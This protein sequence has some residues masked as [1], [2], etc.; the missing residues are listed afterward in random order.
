MTRKTWSPWGGLWRTSRTCGEDISTV[1]EFGDYGEDLEQWR[2][3]GAFLSSGSHIC[4]FML[5]VIDEQLS[6]CRIQPGGSIFL[7][8][9]LTKEQEVRLNI[10][11][12]HGCLIS[13]QP[14]NELCC[15]GLMSA[16]LEISIFPETQT[17]FSD[18][19]CIFHCHINIASVQYLYS[20]SNLCRKHLLSEW[21]HT[22]YQPDSLLRPPGEALG[23]CFIH[24]VDL[25]LLLPLCSP[26]PPVQWRVSGSWGC[27]CHWN[28]PGSQV[29]TILLKFLEETILTCLSFDHASKIIEKW[30]NY[31][32]TLRTERTQGCLRSEGKVVF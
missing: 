30:E 14:K 9:R 15:L 10:H 25:T 17:R 20:Q 18:L 22:S 3:L 6:I 28:W 29:S 4:T 24:C 16:G 32:M 13:L 27:A 12:S 23:P 21:P 31:V 5:R 26:A 11:S 2:S 1:R 19:G 8:Y 7:N